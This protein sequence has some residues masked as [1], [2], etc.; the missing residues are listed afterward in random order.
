MVAGDR[1][2][3]PHVTYKLSVSGVGLELNSIV[4]SKIGKRNY[5]KLYAKSMSLLYALWNYDLWQQESDYWI[6]GTK[7]EKKE[8]I[9]KI[10]IT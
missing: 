7:L 10:M 3:E 5:I 9:M 4:F 6:K 1:W 8:D 2:C